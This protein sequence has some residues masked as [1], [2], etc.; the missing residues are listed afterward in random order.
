M[1]VTLSSDSKWELRRQT[2]GLRGRTPECRTGPLSLG[3]PFCLGGCTSSK[4]LTERSGRTLLKEATRDSPLLFSLVGI[5][6]LMKQALKDYTRESTN[7]NQ[8]ILGALVG[9]KFVIKRRDGCKLPMQTQYSGRNYRE[10]D[11][12]LE[13][14]RNSNKLKGDFKLIVNGDVL[15]IQ[16][17]ADCQLI[18][19]PP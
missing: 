15:M 1:Y 3:A 2:I 7:E 18:G 6:P 14:I 11:F 9:H 8:R 12:N 10:D 16:S 5:T 4:E 19:T 17:G 13:P